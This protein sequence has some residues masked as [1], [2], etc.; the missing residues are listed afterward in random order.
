M[1]LISGNKQPRLTVKVSIPKREQK[2]LLEYVYCYSCILYL[3]CWNLDLSY[4]ENTV[5]PDQMASDQDPQFPLC[6]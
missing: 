5:D 4:L 6:L 2:E 1:S 3:S